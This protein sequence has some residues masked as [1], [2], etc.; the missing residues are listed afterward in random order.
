MYAFDLFVGNPNHSPFRLLFSVVYRI[1]IP[2]ISLG[3]FG[4]WLLI[5][6][7]RTAGIFVCLAAWVPLTLLLLI[8]PFAFTVDRYVFV[9][10]PFWAIL[11]AIAF[12]EMFVQTGKRGKLLALGILLLLVADPL[13][14]DALY[15]AYQNGNRPDWRGAWQIVSREK[16]DGDLV[17]ATRPELGHYYLDDEVASINSV[18]PDTIER[19]GNRVWFVI[20]EAT[21]QVDPDLEQWIGPRSG[22]SRTRLAEKV[23]LCKY[24]TSAH[25]FLYSTIGSRRHHTRSFWV[26]RNWG[27]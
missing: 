11:G 23:R 22:C 18:D 3:V 15:F 1:G 6:E 21:G 16:T 12:R 10:L 19:D 17:L 9:I 25:S 8:S 2:L 27:W 14:Q 20:D 5:A 4:G 13:G 26:S 7:R 24:P